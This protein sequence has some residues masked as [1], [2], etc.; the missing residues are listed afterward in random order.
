MS[1]HR[2]KEVRARLARVHGHVHAV[3]AMLDEGRPYPDV[4][5]Q[6]KAIRA[7]LDKA[8]ALLLDDLIHECEGAPKRDAQVALDT[9]RAAVKAIT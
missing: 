4:L 7:A 5:H 8:T 9:L 1:H 2:T 6:L 3:V